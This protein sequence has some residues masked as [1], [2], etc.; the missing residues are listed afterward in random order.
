MR[1]ACSDASCGLWALTQVCPVCPLSVWLTAGACRY[2]SLAPEGSVAKITGKEGLV[3]TGEVRGSCQ[4]GGVRLLLCDLAALGALLLMMRLSACLFWLA[5][6]TQHARTALCAPP[7]CG[8]FTRCSCPRVPPYL[9]AA[10]LSLTAGA[11][12]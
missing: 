5:A 12:L 1:A 11:V 2:G 8:G 9:T 3:F 4:H 10:G 6:A 7:T